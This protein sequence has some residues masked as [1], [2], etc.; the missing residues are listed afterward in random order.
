[1]IIHI[2]GSSFL[3]GPW[4]L[5]P[6]YYL[7][8]CFSFA[9]VFS[10]LV[11]LLSYCFYDHSRCCEANWGESYRSENYTSVDSDHR[12]SSEQRSQLKPDIFEERCVTFTIQCITSVAAEAEVTQI[13]SLQKRQTSVDV[14]EHRSLPKCFKFTIRFASVRFAVILLISAGCTHRFNFKRCVLQP[15][16]MILTFNPSENYQL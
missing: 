12:V 2:Q 4:S 16:G 8:F 10:S 11:S 13:A 14:V 3:P 7:N 6:P 1:M 9:I 15:A 5:L